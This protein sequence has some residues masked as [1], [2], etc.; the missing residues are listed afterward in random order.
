MVKGS[1]IPLLFVTEADDIGLTQMLA[2]FPP[3]HGGCLEM[4]KRHVTSAMDMRVSDILKRD[5]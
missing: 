2:P 1:F 5:T 4:P 3:F